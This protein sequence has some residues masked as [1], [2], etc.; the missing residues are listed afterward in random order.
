MYKW[1]YVVYI[2]KL[3]Y[4]IQEEKEVPYGIPAYTG[5]FRAL[6]IYILEFGSTDG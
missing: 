2:G 1:I 5:P 4:E 6:Y 3:Q